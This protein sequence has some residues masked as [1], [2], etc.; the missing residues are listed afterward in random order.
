MR[1]SKYII[2]FV[3][4][5]GVSV[6]GE[7]ERVVATT[8][9]ISGVLKEIGR[10][11]IEVITFV[12]PGMCPGHFDLKVKHLKILESS[13]Y[14]FAHGYEKYVEKLRNSVKNPSFRIFYVREEKNW[15]RPDIHIKVAEKIEKIISSLFPENRGY[16]Q[17]NLKKV[18]NETKKIEKRIR[19]MLKERRLEGKKVICNEY[20]EDLLEYF[21]FV[22][23]GTYGRKEE[24]TSRKIVSLI[25][26]CR[27]E[28][29]FFVVDNLQAG[30]D[31]GKVFSGNV[32]PLHIVFSNFP[33]VFEREINLNKTLI[34]NFKRIFISYGNPGN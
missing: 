13:P 5:C 24:L 4:L 26:V 28:K 16:Y 20:L 29:V 1:K 32:Y 15:L 8:T 11:R 2:L 17:S 23:V 21:G 18:I 31:A 14:L 30:P 22:V 3:V 33:G 27:K 6:F 19:R 25:E 34:E 7:N 9:L 10:E 12:P